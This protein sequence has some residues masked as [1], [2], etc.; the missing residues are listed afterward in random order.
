M[1]STIVIRTADVVIVGRGMTN[2]SYGNVP[3]GIWSGRSGPAGGG[4]PRRQTGPKSKLIRSTAGTPV[5]TIVGN[6]DMHF[7]WLRMFAK[8]SLALGIPQ[9]E[10]LRAAA[11]DCQDMLQVRQFLTGQGIFALFDVPM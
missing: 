7:E 6:Y 8:P 4:V 3:H 11:A 1:D 5:D 10:A 9:I 2:A